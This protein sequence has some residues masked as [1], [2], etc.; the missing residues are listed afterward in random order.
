MA[1]WIT[2]RRAQPLCITCL[3]CGQ[4]SYHP[5]DIGERYCVCCHVFS[6]DKLVFDNLEERTRVAP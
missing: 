6:E 1:C 2:F 4:V 5:R 3:D